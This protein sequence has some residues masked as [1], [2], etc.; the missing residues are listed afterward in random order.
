MDFLR[1]LGL[2]EQA[3]SEAKRAARPQCPDRVEAR[4]DLVLHREGLPVP[5]GAELPG[6]RRGQPESI[7]HERA[8]LGTQG[9]K[10]RAPIRRDG[11]TAG[12]QWIDGH[13]MTAVVLSRFDTPGF[14]AP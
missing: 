13:D 8:E 10:R 9:S 12:E 11:E 7:A 2:V 6:E 1:S 4:A 5:A 3:P 14:E